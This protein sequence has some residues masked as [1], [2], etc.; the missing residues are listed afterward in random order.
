VV[1]KADAGLAVMRAGAVKVDGDRDLGLGGLAADGGLAQ[2]RFPF[3]TR[4]L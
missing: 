1:E 4:A 2:R 3:L